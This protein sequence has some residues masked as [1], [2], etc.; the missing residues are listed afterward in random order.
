MRVSGLPFEDEAKMV[1]DLRAG[2]REAFDRLVSLYYDRLHRLAYSMAGCEEDARDLTQETFLAAL[3]SI[4]N[5]R[6]EARLSTWLIAILRNQYT[7]YLRGERKWRHAPLEAVETA[8]APAPAPPVHP[9]VV[10]I[11][12]RLRKLP[13]DLRTT[14]VL[15]YLDGMKYAE[16]AEAM[17]C[18]IGTVRS[19][20]FEARE[21]LKRMMEGAA[22]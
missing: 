8:A 7:L 11:L 1:S 3:E 9:G 10:A 15:F 19:R 14:L 6:A 21:R 5:F 20:L 17:N 2:R 22:S 18:P 12:E 4:G 13:E 16:I